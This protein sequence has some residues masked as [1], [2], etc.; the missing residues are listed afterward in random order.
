MAI[1]KFCCFEN[2]NGIIFGRPLFIREEYEISFGEAVKDAL[3]GLNIPVI[4][5]A[6]IGH[7]APQMA[8]VNGGFSKIYSSKGKGNIRNYFI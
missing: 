2:C 3:K 5:D 4:L 7:K 8:I 6:D 1:K